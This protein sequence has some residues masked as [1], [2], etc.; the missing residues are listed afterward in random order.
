MSQNL[1]LRAK[2]LLPKMTT[3]KEP[4]AAISLSL[5]LKTVTSLMIKTKS[6]IF[7]VTFNSFNSPPALLTEVKALAS[8]PRLELS[9]YLISPGFTIILFDP[10]PVNSR[11]SL[12]FLRPI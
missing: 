4:T 3:Y 8:S 1:A 7:F 9:I 10:L 2:A 6:L 5:T 11:R 12:R